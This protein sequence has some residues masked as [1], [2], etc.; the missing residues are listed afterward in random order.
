[1]GLD[2]AVVAA[3]YLL[4][5]VS[6]AIVICRLC[7][8]PD[9]RTEGSGNPGATNVLRFGGKKAAAAVFAGDLLKGLIP[10]VAA[11]LLALSPAAVALVGLAAFAGH[12][13]PVFF[14]FRGGKGVATSL[15]VL[16]GF[17]WPA[18]LLLAALWIVMALVFRISSLAAITAALAAPA[19]M[20][21]A[22]AQTDYVW[23][24]LAMSLVLLWRHRSNLRNLIR[25]VEPRIGR[26]RGGQEEPRS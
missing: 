14:G 3:A 8:L 9:P 6:S 5:S 25:G 17:T 15:G 4:G 19:V 10:V 1:M 12:L 13:F 18:A 26:K 20:W 7:G 23:A 21:L 2:I 24:T 11:R 22:E 16:L